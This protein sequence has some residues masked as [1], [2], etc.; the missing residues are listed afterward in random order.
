MSIKAL[1]VGVSDY[2][3]IKQ[4]NLPFCANDIVAVYKALVNGLAVKKENIISLGDT[5]VVTTSDFIEA[6][7]F[8]IDNIKDDDTFILYF[9]GHGG[10]LSG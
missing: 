1:V 9:S 7:R 4:S 6:L 5:E 10:N 8:M 2:S 3:T